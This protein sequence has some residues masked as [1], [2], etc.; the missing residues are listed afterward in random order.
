M[1]KN[2]L[3][4]VGALALSASLAAPAMADKTKF[5]FWFGLTGDL[6]Q[7]VGEVCQHFNDLQADFEVVCTS[8]GNYY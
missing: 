8:Q 4:A 3:T 6:A 5:D 1:N 2:L 7:R